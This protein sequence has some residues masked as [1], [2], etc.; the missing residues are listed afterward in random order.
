VACVG[1]AKMLAEDKSAS[2]DGYVIYQM[3]CWNRV[4]HTFAPSGKAAPMG[5]KVIEET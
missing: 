3:N 4:V 1:V 2:I 5:W